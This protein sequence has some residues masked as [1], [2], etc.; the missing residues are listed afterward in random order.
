MLDRIGPSEA[1]GVPLETYEPRYHTHEYTYANE[2]INIGHEIRVHTQHDASE[3][4]NDFLLLLLSLGKQYE[5]RGMRAQTV[6]LTEPSV[7]PATP[8]AHSSAPSRCSCGSHR[9]ARRPLGSENTQRSSGAA[10]PCGCRARPDCCQRA[11]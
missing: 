2:C 3:Q 11:R 5:Q 10:S 1:I 4:G 8:F 9:T 7:M 6:I